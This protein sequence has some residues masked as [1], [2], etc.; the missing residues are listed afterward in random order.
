MAV[1]LR[2]HD[3]MGA[4]QDVRISRLPAYHGKPVY[5]RWYL[6]VLGLIDDGGHGL[7]CVMSSQER[8]LHLAALDRALVPQ[9]EAS[10]PVFSEDERRAGWPAVMNLE[11]IASLQ[12]PFAGGDEAGGRAWDALHSA[13]EHACE[14][15]QLV[16]ESRVTQVVQECKQPKWTG[17][18]RNMPIYANPVVGDDTCYS[19]KPQALAAWLHAQGET[20]SAHIAA[21]FALSGV[22][23]TP[24]V[25]D[26]LWLRACEVAGS[27]LTAAEKAGGWPASMRPDSLT[28][29]QWP[30]EA[31]GVRRTL[32]TAVKDACEGG[33]L[34]CGRDVKTSR[35]QSPDRIPNRMTQARDWPACYVI[36]G[37]PYAYTPEPYMVETVTYHVAPA[38]FAG[39]LAVQKMEP[40]EHMRA[41][42]DVKG[43]AWP[44][45][46]A[47]DPAQKADASPFPLADW[48]ALVAYRKANRGRDWGPGNQLVIA[49]AELGQRIAGGKATESDALEEMA[50]ELGMRSRE[51]LR[52]VLKMPVPDRKRAKKKETVAST[53]SSTQV[54]NGKRQPKAA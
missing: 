36:D 38:A 6:A 22:V 54:L 50:K 23:V 37:R 7:S 21:W 47:A 11:Q 46:V 51:A 9:D 24:A 14:C 27:T 10:G 18:W 40:S 19:V 32:G 52:K 30:A 39:W 33:G 4:A 49:K 13:L 26:V 41:W 25:V 2:W 15:G 48:S 20:P 12:R 42:F 53:S 1:D 8:Q 45:A 35:V 5:A 16:S 17:D 29:L 31:V 3:A 34:P 28:A 43:V 44:P